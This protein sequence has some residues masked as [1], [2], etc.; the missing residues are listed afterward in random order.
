MPF[1]RMSH[2][3]LLRMELLK[4]MLSNDV[5]FNILFRNSLLQYFTFGR[6]KRTVFGRLKYVISGIIQYFS[7]WEIEMCRSWETEM[8]NTRKIEMC[9]SRETEISR[10]RDIVILQFSGDWNLFFREIKHAILGRLNC[11]FLGVWTSHFQGIEM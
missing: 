8:C 11:S 2:G 9:H 6:L 4:I 3:F 7:F 5:P 1:L 10:F